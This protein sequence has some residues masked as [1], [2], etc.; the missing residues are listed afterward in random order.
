MEKFRLSEDKLYKV[1][2]VNNFDFETT[3]ELTPLQGIIGQDRAI[4]AMDFGLKM[5]KKG[6]NIYVSGAW[7]TGRNSYVKLI[8]DSVAIKKD[9]AKDWVYVFNFKNPYNPL[10]LSLQRGEAKSFSKLVKRAIFFIRK[11]IVDVFNSR[12]YENARTLMMSE[13]NNKTQ[14]I[15]I[16]LNKIGKKHGFMFSHNDQGLVSVPLKSNGEPMTE[17]EYHSITDKQYEE[18]KNNSNALSVEAVDYFNKLRNEEEKLATKLKNLDENFARKAIEFHI[19]SIGMKIH[20]SNEL[21]KY[22]S[23]IIEDIIENINKFKKDD[24][25]EEVDNPLI[26]LGQ[27]SN[28]DFFNRYLVNVFIDNSNR[29]SAPVIFESNPTYYNLVGAVEY[30][31]EMGVLRTDFTQIKPGAL[32]EA[33]GGFL[34]LQARDILSLPY[35]WQAIKRSLVTQ[36]IQ[37]ESLGKLVGAIVTS[38]IKPQPIPLDIKII[39][40]GDYY[41]YS[42]LYEYDEEFRKLFRIMA[43]FDLEMARD[44]DNIKRLA[45]FIATHCEKEG[46]KSFDRSAVAKIIEYSSRLAEDQ[47]KLSSRLNKIVG[48]LFEAD[49]WASIFGDSLVTEKHIEK[50]LYEINQRTNKVEEIIFEMIESG[51]YLLDVDGEKVGEIN[52]LAVMGTGQYS[53]GKPSKITVSAYRGKAGIVNIEREA[54][55]SGSIHDKG[56][57]ILTGYMGY[58]YAADKPLA[59]SAS[60]VFEQ[61]YGGIEGDSASSTELYALLSSLSGKPINQG[62]AV[63]GSVNQRGQ[64]QPIGGA[65]EKIEGFFKVCKIKGFT[66]KQGVIIPI[67]N[68]KNLMLDEEVI[69]AVIK[70]EF[71]IYA[72][73]NTDEGIEILTGIKA[74]DIDQEGTIHYLVNKKLEELADVAKGKADE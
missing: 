50:T 73:S 16:E 48:I 22:L 25:D 3:D 57:M 67:Q 37:I 9:M 49:K 12:D 4:K 65:N 69:Q 2:D 53:F 33:N 52:G 18:L 8:T 70:R 20:L 31:N 24:D 29:K 71:H 23:S 42:L 19:N 61:L 41:T 17:K 39:I 45:R 47:N 55:I 72:V 44:E 10:A 13:Y 7:G 28:E 6:Y 11:Q 43:D 5:D 59:L 64:I 56:V 27:K 63:T 40:I 35:A 15:I 21:N 68:I 74:G 54:R 62:I 26:I 51:D 32:H 36:Q 66:G 38:T 30:K 1:C 60:I 34:V 14:E 46:L 58:K